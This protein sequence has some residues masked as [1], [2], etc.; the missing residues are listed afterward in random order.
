M[1]R[2][3]SPICAMIRRWQNR[4]VVA[5]ALYGV[6]VTTLQPLVVCAT[7]IRWTAGSSSG[8]AA[9]TAPRSQRYWDE[10]KIVRPDYAKTDAELAAERRG[11]PS[12]SSSS[13]GSSFNY[14][15]STLLPVLLLL[16]VVGVYS[17]SRYL[18]K[19]KNGIRLGGSF[20]VFRSLLSLVPAS[21]NEDSNDERARHARLERFEI[22]SLNVK[23]E[24]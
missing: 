8:E 16:P 21:N 17:Y 5:F 4:V 11:G 19:S 22:G 12:A 3:L 14:L 9:E 15:R 2:G 1:S 10:H 13:S 24:D 18:E 23:K 20:S 7:D 6:V